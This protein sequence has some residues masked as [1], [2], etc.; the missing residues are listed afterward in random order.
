MKFASIGLLLA[1]LS[2][3]TAANDHQATR[4]RRTVEVEAES[5]EPEQT[6]S[7]AAK[8]EKVECDLENPVQQFA[9]LA[10]LRSLASNLMFISPSKGVDNNGTLTIKPVTYA[11]G[12][13]CDPNEEGVVNNWGNCT[14]EPDDYNSL[15]EILT[16]L[17]VNE[18][19]VA[20]S[21]SRM[22]HEPEPQPVDGHK[23]VANLNKQFEYTC[24][25]E[26]LELVE[27]QEMLL[28]GGGGEVMERSRTWG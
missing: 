4:M 7:G 14:I 12:Y 10:A 3:A 13:D 11:D 24:A 27:L 25:K 16:Y 1:S 21:L 15:K 6:N 2:A 18:P 8:K 19:P 5:T 17:P 28:A 22:P 20:T 9:R 26:L 23:F